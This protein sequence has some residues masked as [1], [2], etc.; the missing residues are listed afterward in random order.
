MG[1][2]EVTARSLEEGPGKAA[3][4][5]QDGPDH[6]PGAETP[7]RTAAPT[8]SAQAVQP[9]AGFVE[10]RGVTRR[11]GRLVALHDVNLSVQPGEFVVVTGPSEAGKTTLLRLIHG[12]VRPNKGLIRVDGFRLERR[13]RRFLPRL[14]R[15]VA[16]VSQDH[17]LLHDMSVRGN[18]AFALQVSDLWLP[19]HEVRARAQA[20]LDEVG[21][22]KRPGAYPNQLSGGQQRRLAIAR[23]LVT[24]P[25]L[26]L[27]DEPTS[28]L[29][30]SNAERVID[31]L[32][33]CCQA[34]TTVVVATHDVELV[35][36]RGHRVVELRA[37]RI[38]A[39][40]P[41]TAPISSNGA[42]AR[43]IADGHRRDLGIRG[44]IGT[45][46]QFALGYLP[47]PPAP[48]APERTP[49]D[50]KGLAAR[51]AQVALGYRPAPAGVLPNGAWKPPA[52]VVERLTTNGQGIR[53]TV[54]PPA[55]ARRAAR[56]EEAGAWRP[57]PTVAAL[58]A[59]DPVAAGSA[60]GQSNGNAGAGS[61]GA[62]AANGSGR[63]LRPLHLLAQVAQFALGYVPPPATRP[64][65]KPAA[66]VRSGTTGSLN[67]LRRPWVPVFN[68]GR[69]CI[70]GAVASWARNLGTVA[71]ALGSIALLLAVAGGLAVGG[72]ALRTLLVTQSREAAVLHVYLSEDAAGDEVDQAHQAL[73]AL[74]HVRSVH[75][76]DK[77]QALQLAR[78]RPGLGDLAAASD[79][80]PFPASLE[81]Q[82][83]QPSD[84]AA[85]AGVAATEPAVDTRRPTS[86]DAG[87]YDR[88]RQFTVVAAAIAGAFGLLMLAITYAISSNSIRTAVLA[89]RDEL[90]TM[91]L[92]GASRW[93]I[94]TRL[95]VEGA[96]TGGVAGLIAA[97][98]VVGASA[99]SYYAAHHVF[100]QLLPGVTSFTVAGVVA[101]V[102]AA[103]IA[104]GSVSALFAFRR[105]RT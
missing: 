50:L 91:Q 20:R 73:A 56:A 66:A 90:L 33:R 75:Y 4:P 41:A 80:N 64:G 23:A 17:R 81:V 46:M 40:R 16:A 12:D 88:L 105:L 24:G 39:D 79:S 7:V 93:L 38:V 42:A 44:P 63:G 82:V 83:D 26:L 31:L 32:E 3:E 57:P 92:V 68:L 101:A 85:V 1:A 36:S 47:P 65:G 52:E 48:P 96:L 55:A 89:R 49:L 103:G 104:L 15:R 5:S 59:D 54:P 60:S 10:L 78:K 14:R 72:F 13:W 8:P 29:D 37:G 102:T 30:R 99:A 9:P 21:L 95:G 67:R 70:G 98:S 34:G 62:S 25:V 45:L 74:P 94:R 19:R 76:I 2:V 87:T 35:R 53:S 100:V 71:P 43:L 58:I 51:I 18:V 97:G 27:A 77:D 84:V 11:Y 61:D 28:N 22:G 6:L 69:L 86:Y